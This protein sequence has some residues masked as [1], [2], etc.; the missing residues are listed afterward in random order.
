V[1]WVGRH[2]ALLALSDRLGRSLSRAV[3]DLAHWRKR[4]DVEAME[5]LAFLRQVKFPYEFFQD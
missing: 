1:A 5:R 3:Y 4:K 2:S